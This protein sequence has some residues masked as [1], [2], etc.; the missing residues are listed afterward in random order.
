MVNF[1]EDGSC[2]VIRF[3]SKSSSGLIIPGEDLMK[4]NPYPFTAHGFTS[5][6]NGRIGAPEWKFDGYKNYLEEGAE[7]FEVYNDGREVLIAVFETR[8]KVTKFYRVD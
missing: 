8:N 5:G 4:D 7:L 3:K 1:V 6:K 2:G